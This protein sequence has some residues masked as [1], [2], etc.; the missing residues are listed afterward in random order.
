MPSA[1]LTDPLILVAIAAF[2][3]YWLG[4]CTREVMPWH[5]S[6]FKT[7]ATGLLAVTAMA[8]PNLWP[9]A[10]GLGFGALGDLALSR[11]GRRNFLLGM[12]AFALGHFAYA[13]GFILRAQQIGMSAPSGLAII[14]GLIFLALIAS[15]EV[16]LAPRTAELRAPVRAYGVII[17]LMALACLMLPAHPGLPLL[18]AGV[19]LFVIS[20]TLLAL[21]LFVVTD[22]GHKT[23][24]SRMLWP[25]YWLG[26]ALILIGATPY[27]AV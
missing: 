11:P 2:V 26:Q 4:Y 5:G 16:W 23:L 13:A 1:S 6:F 19:C 27:W 17:G 9:I 7:V 21:R 15:T 22:P 3:I 20:D 24:L 25:A 8:S 12:A 14:A 10:L 18:R